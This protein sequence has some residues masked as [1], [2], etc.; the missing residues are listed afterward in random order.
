MRK[1]VGILG[2]AVGVWVL[3]LL[4]FHLGDAIKLGVFFSLY[5]LFA[6]MSQLRERTY[7]LKLLLLFFVA[8][9]CFALINRFLM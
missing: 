4:R 6:G 3:I 9:L 1:L 5:V 2:V 7:W 8:A